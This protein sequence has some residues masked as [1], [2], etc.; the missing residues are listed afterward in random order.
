MVGLL[1]GGDLKNENVTAFYIFGKP[2]LSRSKFHIPRGGMS[3]TM[4]ET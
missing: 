2:I 4:K 3:A 1:I